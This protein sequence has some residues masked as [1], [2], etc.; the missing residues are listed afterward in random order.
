VV[1]TLIA[2]KPYDPL[3]LKY[4]QPQ[5][6]NQNPPGNVQVLLMKMVTLMKT[7]LTRIR[8][9]ELNGR[10]HIINEERRKPPIKVSQLLS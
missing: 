9:R 10:I 5:E 6:G 2:I 7:Y 1:K 3:L 4:V 8:R